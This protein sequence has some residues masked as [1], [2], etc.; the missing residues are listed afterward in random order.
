MS[1]IEIAG[2][3]RDAGALL[4]INGGSLLGRY[5][6]QARR[7]A[8]EL[9]QRG[10]ADFVCSD[11]HTRGAPLI[12]E[13]HDCL[14]QENGQEQ[15]DMLLRVNPARLLAGQRPL[16]VPPLRPGRRSVWQRVTGIFR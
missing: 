15:A 7:Y 13:Y 9:L 8:F 3:W 2:E 6:A 16:P 11:Y 14:V 10:W 5:G 4:Q 1:A 12:R